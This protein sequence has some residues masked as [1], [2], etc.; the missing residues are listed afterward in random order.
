MC[1]S[2]NCHFKRKSKSSKYK[3]RDIVEKILRTKYKL[4]QKIIKKQSR[5]KKYPTTNQYHSVPQNWINEN[6][7]VEEWY[8]F[9]INK[10]LER[11]HSRGEAI[12]MNN[13]NQ[14]FNKTWS[15]ILS[16]PER[17][18][19]KSQKNK[20]TGSIKKNKNYC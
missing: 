3:V 4:K 8:K 20:R 9:E 10:F 11:L 14:I 6:H 17:P 16:S 7:T 19:K 1:D 5:S 15:W 13:S 2:S 18:F 12:N